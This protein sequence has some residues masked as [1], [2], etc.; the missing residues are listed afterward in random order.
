M[1]HCLSAKKFMNLEGNN[2]EL[3]IHYNMGDDYPPILIFSDLNIQFYIH[4]KKTVSNAMKYPLFI[5]ILQQMQSSNS[6]TGMWDLVTTT[7]N[8]TPGETNV[9]SKFLIICFQYKCNTMFWVVLLSPSVRNLLNICV[10][11]WFLKFVN[12]IELMCPF[13]R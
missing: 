2:S 4:L 1:L 9:V 11:S 12:L 13:D 8:W 3:K 7:N 10:I 6:Q 5:N